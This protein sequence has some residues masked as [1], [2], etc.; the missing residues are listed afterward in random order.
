[1]SNNSRHHQETSGQKL[2]G[3]SL[4]VDHEQTGERMDEWTQGKEWMR[5]EVRKDEEEQ[6]EKCI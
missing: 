5:L 4:S 2:K 1:M 3:R 6:R